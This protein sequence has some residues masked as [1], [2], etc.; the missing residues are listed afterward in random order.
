M[1]AYITIV[2]LSAKFSWRFCAH[3]RHEPSHQKSR[4][5]KRYVLR[6]TS[7][8][9]EAL[10]FARNGGCFDAGHQSQ[11]KRSKFHAASTCRWGRETGFASRN[12]ARYISWA[13]LLWWW[14]WRNSEG[15]VGGRIG[16][17]KQH[18]TREIQKSE[19]Q[20]VGS[21]CLSEM[22]EKASRAGWKACVIFA[23]Y[24]SWGSWRSGKIDV[25]RPNFA[26][27][28]CAHTV[29]SPTFAQTSWFLLPA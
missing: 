24:Y 26:D 13:S 6:Q 23:H 29:N 19:R 21:N 15:E 25:N 16:A 18:N 1:F 3:I 17:D 20:L 14:D 2:F 7:L 8:T 5:D 28:C 12:V 10:R 4:F 9:Q 27:F 22:D 11:P